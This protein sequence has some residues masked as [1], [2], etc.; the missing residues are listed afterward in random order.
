MVE[1]IVEVKPKSMIRI[2]DIMMTF[3][4]VALILFAYAFGRYSASCEINA[5]QQYIDT[6]GRIIIVNGSMFDYGKPLISNITGGR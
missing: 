3:F 4:I 6:G 2:F 5:I 1:N